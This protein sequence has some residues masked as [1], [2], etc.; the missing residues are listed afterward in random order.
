MN[1]GEE[2]RRLEVEPMQWPAQPEPQRI[3]QPM[4][5]AEPSAAPESSPA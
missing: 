1:L 3:A 5:S 2:K 4:P